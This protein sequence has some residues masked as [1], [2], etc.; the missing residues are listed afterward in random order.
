MRVDGYVRVSRR[1]GRKGPSF[2]SPDVQRDAIKAWAKAHGARVRW[3]E[4]IDRSGREGKSRPVFDEVMA[5]I[6]AGKSDG[7]VVWKLSRFGRSLIESATRIR[8]IEAA[9]SAVY[10]ATEGDQS[11]LTRNILLAVAEDESDRIQ[12]G[13]AEAQSRAIARGVWIG[14]APLGYVRTADGTLAI[15]EHTAPIV[16]EAFTRAARGGLHDAMAYLAERVPGRRW[17]TDEARRLLASRAYLGESGSNRAAHPPITD[18]ATFAAA[19]H[20][21][22]PRRSTATT[23]SRASPRVASGGAGLAG[24]LQHV[25]GREYR[26]LRCAKPACR[27]GSSI[28]AQALTEHVRGRV[29]ALLGDRR[30]TV[31]FDVADDLAAARGALDAAEAERKRYA[32][33][34][35]LP[36]LLGPDAW[37]AGAVARSEAVAQAQERYT[38]LAG[39]AAHAEALPLAEAL[40]DDD[41]L[42]SALRAMDV[43]IAV[44]RGRGPIAERATLRFPWLDLDDGA[45]VAAA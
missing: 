45:G 4:E 42:L 24:Q 31:R 10:S 16:A 32:A 20:P 39:T 33:D 7:V 44:A 36:A 38:E 43:S 27:A 13:W 6:A 25:E 18:A 12:T 34:L 11:K 1:N 23:C 40:D 30:V 22:R 3:H 9:G 2:I 8:A 21:A 28:G 37:R 14:P 5:R 15:D 41:A 26:R 35:D 29:R 19:Q 17:R